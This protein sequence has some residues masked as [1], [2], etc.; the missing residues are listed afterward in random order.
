MKEVT[1]EL[2]LG[3]VFFPVNLGYDAGKSVPGKGN[4]MNTQRHKMV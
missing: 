3:K 4:H 2:S 1:L